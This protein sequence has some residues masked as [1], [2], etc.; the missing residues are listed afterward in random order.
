MMT[1]ISITLILLISTLTAQSQNTLIKAGH[2]FDARSGKMLDNQMIIIKDGKIKEVGANLKTTKTDTIIDLSNSYV[3]PGLMDC[4]VHITSNLSFRKRNWNDVDVTESNALRAIRGS[5]FAK[6]F[7]DNGFTTIKEIGNDANYATADIIKAIKN[8]L[9]QGP[10]IIYAGK[11]IA[12]YGGQSSGV[13]PEH[14]HFW[15]WEYIDADTHEEIIKAIRKNVYYGAT[16]IKMVTGDN[17]IYDIEDI[18]VAVSEAKKYGLKVTVHVKMG[19]QEATNVILGG[20]AAIEHGFG[21]DNTQLQL[22]KDKGTFLVGT[23]LAFDNWY[24]YG[25]DST[26]AKSWVD[27][28]VDRLKRAY[29]IGT[30]MAF[31]T[32]IVINLPGLNRVQSSLKVLENWKLARIPASYIL[33]CMTINAAELLGIEKER[34]ILEQLYYADIIALK[35]NPLDDIEAIKT[36][37]FVMKEGKVVRLD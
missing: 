25:F 16:V 7:L 1:K 34:G 29:E 28:D 19:G 12:P 27:I 26:R 14:E 24:A 4:H 33:Q 6:Q 31:G 20:A 10:T 18:K 37:Q 15:D 8:G 2:F 3:L 13:N 5:V 9:I 36:V 11:I 17:G 22:M 23:D 21:L 32:D 35:N 30:K